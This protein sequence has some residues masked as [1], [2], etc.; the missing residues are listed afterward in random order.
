MFIFVYGSLKKNKKLHYYLKTAEFIAEAKTCFS[1]PLILSKSG[2]Y[3]YLLNMKNRGKQIKG[4]IY[5]LDYTLLKR[6]DRLEEVPHYYVRKKICVKINGKSREVWCYFAK[7]T[8][9]FLKKELMD[10]F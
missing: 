1:Y 2:W 3:P 5:K 4:E 9:K 7:K 6:L 10:E 8:K